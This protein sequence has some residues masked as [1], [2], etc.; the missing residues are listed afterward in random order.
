[1]NIKE[2][3]KL[4]RKHLSDKIGIEYHTD[5]PVTIYGFNPEENF[6]FTFGLFGPPM[7]GGDNYIA[8]SKATGELRILGR[9]G[10]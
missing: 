8:V 9:L 6:L 3:E 5:P 7:V 1:M 10:D 4:V 2:A